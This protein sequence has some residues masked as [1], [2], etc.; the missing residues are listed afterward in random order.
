MGVRAAVSLL[1]VVSSVGT[2]VGEDTIHSSLLKCNLRT[3]SRP[4]TNQAFAALTALPSGGIL[5][6]RQNPDSH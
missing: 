3:N 1:T 2:V 4:F 5:T 6:I